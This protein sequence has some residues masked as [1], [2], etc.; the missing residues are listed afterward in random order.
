M[1]ELKTL[2]NESNST[3]KMTKK[4]LKKM[5]VIIYTNKVWTVITNEKNLENKMTKKALKEMKVTTYTKM[6]SF[7]FDIG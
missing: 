4:S 7:L 2:L 1:N 6:Y 5:K 3:D